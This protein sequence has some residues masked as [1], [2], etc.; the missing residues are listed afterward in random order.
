MYTITLFTYNKKIG[1]C[2]VQRPQTRG[3][4]YYLS[5]IILLFFCYHGY[6]ICYDPYLEGSSKQELQHRFL[7][8]TGRYTSIFSIIFT[9]GNNFCAFLCRGTTSTIKKKMYPTK[10]HFFLSSTIMCLSIGTP[11]IINFPFVPNGKLII[12]GVPKFVYLTA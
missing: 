6:R 11:K 1:F 10:Q 2:T 12:L 4:F 7:L 8:G 5:G 9:K 3:V